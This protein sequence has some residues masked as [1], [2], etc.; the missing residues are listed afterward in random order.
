MQ[1][2]P[3]SSLSSLTVLARRCPPDRARN[4]H[5]D[6][7]GNQGTLKTA[8]GSVSHVN[9]GRTWPKSEGRWLL[10]YRDMQVVQIRGSYQLTLVL[11]GG[12][13]VDMESES[14]LTDGPLTAPDALPVRLLPEHQE[15]AP[16]LSLFG[17]KILSSVV[18][19][20][21]ALRL[22][23]STGAHLNVK[24]HLQYEAWRATGPGS[25]R[26]ICQPGGGVA[27]WP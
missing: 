16:A 9:G 11:D 17:A 21:G 1:V 19:K 12:A 20:T 7:P 25:L 2:T 26:L 24:P 22:V 4:G 18:F 5:A 10:P 23:F 14:L 3:R 15:V 8:S 13:Q 27:V 6:F